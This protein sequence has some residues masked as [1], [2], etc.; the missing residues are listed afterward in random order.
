MGVKM[1]KSKD[2]STDKDELLRHEMMGYVNRFFGGDTSVLANLLTK[3]SRKKVSVR[4]VQ[5]WLIEKGKPSSRRCPEWAVRLVTEYIEKNPKYFEEL[6]E[7]QLYQDRKET[8]DFSSYIDRDGVRMATDIIERDNFRRNKWHNASM[9]E[10]V[11]EIFKLES[12]LLG[13]VSYHNSVLCT[14]ESELREA[15]NFDDWKKVT[16][17]KLDQNQKKEM[18]LSGLKYDI[19]N[20]KNEFSNSNGLLDE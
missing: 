11:E 18:Y 14:L 20:K 9:T 7:F 12:L 8:R 2:K 3:E 10:L 16:L 15:K 6:K 19:L 13:Y 1:D 17:K 5:S 4:T